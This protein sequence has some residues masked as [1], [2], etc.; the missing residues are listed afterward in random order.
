MFVVLL[1]FLSS[2]N[3]SI[4]LSSSDLTFCRY[5]LFSPLPKQLLP[6]HYLS[7]FLLPTL[8]H[9]RLYKPFS[10]ILFSHWILPSISTL[11]S[12]TCASV[13][14]LVYETFLYSFLQHFQQLYTNLRFLYRSS[15]LQINSPPSI[16]KVTKEICTSQPKQKSQSFV[17]KQ[18]FQPKAS[19]LVCSATTVHHFANAPAERLRKRCISPVPMIYSAKKQHL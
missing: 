7:P 3:L 18:I 12:F 4:C 9:F 19:I 1:L 10:F 17:L 5:A 11:Y 8:F 2:I 15:S 14:L 13:F 6:H 16:D